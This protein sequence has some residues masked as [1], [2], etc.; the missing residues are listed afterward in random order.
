MGP[1][2]D[3]GVLRDVPPPSQADHDAIWRA[4]AI[5]DALAREAPEIII[6]ARRSEDGT[7]RFEVSEPGRAAA[8]Y[9]DPVEL[10]DRLAERHLPPGWESAA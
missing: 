6:T 1:G 9:E 8:A 7:L 5:R 10:L 3:G 4:V 2:Y